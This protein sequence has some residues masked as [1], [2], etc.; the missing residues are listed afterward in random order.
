[1]IQIID[2]NAGNLKSVE[3]ALSFLNIDF[4]IIK[5]GDQLNLNQKTIFPGVGAAGAAMRELKKRGFTN[6]IGR[7]KAP[8]LG[9]CLGMQLLFEN[10]EEDQAKCLG[11]IKGEVKK[12]RGTL[13]VPQIGWN[14]VANKSDR[15]FRGLKKNDFFYFVHSFY[16]ATADKFVIG[17]TDYGISFASAVRY[18]N[19]YG[20][21]FHPEKS[22]T[23]GAKI[24]S[25]FCEL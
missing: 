8:F 11:I 9:I 16:A 15:I 10:S 22:G 13:K 19:F 2:Y 24:L 21:Q 17:K 4:Q 23:S 7:I 6:Q 3:N 12:F 14:R 25:N 5:C 20:L 1:M 18:K